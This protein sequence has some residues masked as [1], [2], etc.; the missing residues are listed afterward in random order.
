LNDRFDSPEYRR[1]RAAYTAQCAFEYFVSILLT[2]AFLAKLLK[3]IGLEDAEIGIIASLVSFSFLFQLFSIL[4]MQKVGEV[5][6]TVIFCHTLSQ[7]LFL[8]VYLVPFL[9]VPEGARGFVAAGG[10][11]S[12]YALQYLV[13]SVLFRW[14]NGY[15]DPRKRGGF[16]AVKEMIS[17]LTGIVFTLAMGFI[18]D[19]FEKKGNLRGGFLVLAGVILFLNICNFVCLCL[20][21]KDDAEETEHRPL[22]EVMKAVFTNRDFLHIVILTCIWDAARYLSVGFLGTYKTVDLAFTVGTV[23]IINT[24][25]N[26]CRFAVSRPFG[27]FSD[28][29]SYAHGY[30]LALGIAAAG[31]AVGCFVAPGTRWLIVLYTVL[32]NVSLAGSNQNSFNMVYSYVEPENMVQAMA[33]RASVGGLVGFASSLVGGKI[34][35]AVQERGNRIF[36]VT[37]YGQQVL[38]GLSCL[39]TVAALVYTGR[40]VEKQ[41]AVK[42]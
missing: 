8:G 22:G 12:G 14:A 2:D 6:R 37:V 11:L 20:I 13:S 26:L 30:R 33:V 25:A 10:M 29:T 36:G 9:P 39:L 31:F 7:F 40:V 41:K 28:R 38:L 15:V 17:L 1:S 34:L 27:V 18:F 32:Y 19:S 35:S 5:K 21:R 42:R 24:A 23:Q 4:L 3:H 16:S